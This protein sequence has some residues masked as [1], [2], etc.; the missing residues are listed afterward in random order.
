[1]GV[2]GPKS[3]GGRDDVR[4][5]LSWLVGGAPKTS[6]KVRLAVCAAA[7]VALIF[8]VPVADEP[9]SFEL[10]AACMVLMGGLQALGDLLYRKSRV[11]GELLRLAGFA[12]AVVGFS[13]F[14]VLL[15]REGERGWFAWAMVVYAGCAAWLVVWTIRER[16]RHGR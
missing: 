12:A 10:F 9:V 16:S 13:L 2:G 11:V 8:L 14:A 3:A 7:G 6:G 1:M 4:G 5:R 15:W